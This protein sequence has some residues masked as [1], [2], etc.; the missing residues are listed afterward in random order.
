MLWYFF[1][2]SL[3]TISSCSGQYSLCPLRQWATASI[4]CFPWCQ[5]LPNTHFI[6]CQ[7]CDRPP[8][9]CSLGRPLL[10][11][12]I[13]PQKNALFSW[14][15]LS[16]GGAGGLPPFGLSGSWCQTFSHP[17]GWALV[18]AVTQHPCKDITISQELF[19][20]V[21]IC[22]SGSDVLGS[23]VLSLCVGRSLS[24]Q[25]YGSQ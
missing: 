22:A 15:S 3:G 4:S 25:P 12:F 16:Q 8:C 19:S 21:Q 1:F 6:F 24:L 9:A 10:C 11:F 13:H 23:D 17:M 5:D 2:P 20:W 18:L 14:G 7:Q